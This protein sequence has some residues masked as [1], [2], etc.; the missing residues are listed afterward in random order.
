MMTAPVWIVSCLASFTY[1][2]LEW[3]FYVTKASFLDSLEIWGRVGVWLVPGLGLFLASLF[4]ALLLEWLRKRF[5]I[6]WRI[7]LAVPAFVL[8]VAGLLLLD[9]FTY[10]LFRNGIITTIGPLRFLYGLVFLFLCYRSWM[11]LSSLRL[12]RWSSLACGGLLAMAGGWG[13]FLWA[14]SDF[15]LADVAVTQKNQEIRK[16]NIIVFSM[17]RVEAEITSAYGFPLKTTP[18]LERFAEGAWIAENA[19]SNCGKTTGSTSSMLTGISP[20][21]THVGFPPQVFRKE[22]A[23]RHLPAIL[24]KQGYHSFQSTIR[25]YADAV[26]MN[27]QGGF[28]L[29]N[30]RRP[31]VPL[32][33]SMGARAIYALNYEYLFS[34]ELWARAK[35]RLLHV[36]GIQDAVNHHFL[37]SRSDMLEAAMDDHMISLAKKFIE[38]QGNNP[39]FAHIHLLSTHGDQYSGKNPR[40]SE[41]EAAKFAKERK[42]FH[43]RLNVV[44]DADVRFGEFLDW[45]ETKGLLEKSI[46]V[47]TA[48]HS[49]DWDTVLRMPLVIRYPGKVIRGRTKE[50]VQLLD[51]S[52]TLL[53]FMGF[54][55]PQWM[56]GQSLLGDLRSFRDR[57]IYGLACFRYERFFLRA[58]WLSQMTEPGPP[59]YGVEMAS[60][61]DGNQWAK[62]NLETNQVTSGFILGHTRPCRERKEPLSEASPVVKKYIEYLKSVG[63][64][65]KAWE[66][67]VP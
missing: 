64:R 35:G 3:L 34:A 12:P 65:A 26:D 11:L 58:A 1:V 45:L 57:P 28:N 7:E 43:G 44:A 18:N 5:R 50:N 62:L 29:A 31:L 40:F 22:Y 60:L 37:V 32:P 41:A 48:D 33:G 20:L 51:L 16:P 30:E 23:F 42:N 36:F 54:E 61:I 2:L 19:F 66:S 59:L 17:D 67:K 15:N 52:P 55:K 47:F 10:T 25:H 24:H 4:I 38:G 46:V 6:S 9:N 8:G 39:F 53:D 21:R 56:E 13:F 49:G 14:F 27:L 63:F